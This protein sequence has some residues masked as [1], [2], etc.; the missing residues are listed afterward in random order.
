MPRFVG[1]FL[2][3]REPAALPSVMAWY[4]DLPRTRRPPSSAHLSHLSGT[5]TV[6]GPPRRLNSSFTACVIDSC[7][8]DAHVVLPWKL[9]RPKH[10]T[11]IRPSPIDSVNLARSAETNVR[12][13]EEKLCINQSSL[14]S[15]GSP[16]PSTSPFNSSRKLASTIDE[17]WHGLHGCSGWRR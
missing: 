8:F 2:E 13:E 3:V 16:A 12:N 7:A 5:S 10:R 4:S 11:C 15:D 14:N 1:D 9:H 17:S 6:E